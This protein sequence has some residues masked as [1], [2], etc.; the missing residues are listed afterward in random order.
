[1]ETKILCQKLMDG[2]RNLNSNEPE[3]KKRGHINGM[4]TQVS[5]YMTKQVCVKIKTLKTHVMYQ[6]PKETSC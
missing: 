1:M 3:K 5:D 6:L 2:L 4:K